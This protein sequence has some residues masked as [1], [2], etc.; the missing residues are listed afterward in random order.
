MSSIHNEYRFL[1]A[2]PNTGELVS[3][4]P[5]RNE[6]AMAIIRDAKRMR[7]GQKLRLSQLFFKTF[8]E[9]KDL[10]RNKTPEGYNQEAWLKAIETFDSPE[11]KV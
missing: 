6:I 8:C 3:A 11:H 5:I 7:R 10:A 1:Y 4:D 9:S 2:H